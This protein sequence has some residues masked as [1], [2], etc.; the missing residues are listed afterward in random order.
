VRACPLAPFGINERGQ[1][2]FRRGPANQ[3]EEEDEAMRQA[4]RNERA[5]AFAP[6]LEPKFLL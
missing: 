3:T 1:L 4:N 6:N 5:L 2:T